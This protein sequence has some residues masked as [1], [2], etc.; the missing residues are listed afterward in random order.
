M[1]ERRGEDGARS[2]AVDADARVG[3]LVERK[4]GKEESVGELTGLVDRWGMEGKAGEWRGVVDE[5]SVG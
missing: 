5:G 3:L 1:V 4:E 2:I